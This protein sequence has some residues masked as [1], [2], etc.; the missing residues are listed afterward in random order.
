MIE[1]LDDSKGVEMFD[2][3]L[4]TALRPLTF[5]LMLASL[6]SG[7]YKRGECEAVLQRRIPKQRKT[8]GNKVFAYILKGQGRGIDVVRTAF[9]SCKIAIHLISPVQL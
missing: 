8:K 1:I 4:G 6:F 7:R 5:G 3:V 9:V 2:A